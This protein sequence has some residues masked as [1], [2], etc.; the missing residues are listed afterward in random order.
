MVDDGEA[1]ASGQ[2]LRHGGD[3]GVGVRVRQAHWRL[4]QRRAAL[5]DDM[6]HGVAHRVVDVAEHQDFVTAAQVK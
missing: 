1:C 2:M 5:F 3:D 4:D 6:T